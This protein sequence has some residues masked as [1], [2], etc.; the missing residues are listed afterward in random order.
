MVN[1]SMAKTKHVH[2]KLTTVQKVARHE[3]FMKLTNALTTAQDAYQEEARA[4]A[5]EHGR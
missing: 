2:T 4:I 3:K 5:Q 1:S